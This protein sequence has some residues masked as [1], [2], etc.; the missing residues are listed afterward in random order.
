[1]TT[2]KTENDSR[3]QISLLCRKSIERCAGTFSM[4]AKCP[5]AIF[6]VKQCALAIL[7]RL[8][9]LH[10][11]SAMKGR[12]TDKGSTQVRISISWWITAI[13]N[14]IIAQSALMSFN[15]FGFFYFFARQRKSENVEC[16]KRIRRCL[17]SKCTYENEF[18]EMTDK[19]AKCSS[20]I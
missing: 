7:N 13:Q 20:S 11:R 6:T 18:I 2:T 15:G 10:D 3:A 8:H 1:M 17:F 5:T 16:K 12:Q 4:P 14:N 9:W 19:P